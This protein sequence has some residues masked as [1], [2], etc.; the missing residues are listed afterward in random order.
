MSMQMKKIG[1]LLKFD[2][3]FTVSSKGQSGGLALMWNLE[4]NINIISFS[5]CHIDAEAQIE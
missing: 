5:S 2:C 1:K 4:I 3:Y